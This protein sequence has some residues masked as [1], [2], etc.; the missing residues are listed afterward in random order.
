MTSFPR[1]FLRTDMAMWN[2]FDSLPATISLSARFRVLCVQG[3]LLFK[4]PVCE[5]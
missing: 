3:E 1:V 2:D 5:V 4:N